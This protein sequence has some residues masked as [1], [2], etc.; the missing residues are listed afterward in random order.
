MPPPDESYFWVA[1]NGPA[2]STAPYALPRTFKCSPVPELLLGFSTLK[3][4]KS[5]HYFALTA[6]LPEVRHR[7]AELL[8]S[9]ISSIKPAHPEKP[10]RE[11][12]IWEFSK[13]TAPIQEK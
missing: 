8:T 10:S 5:F 1:I 7:I 12:T 11:P 6:P 9:V 2:V 4:A 3:E 13:D